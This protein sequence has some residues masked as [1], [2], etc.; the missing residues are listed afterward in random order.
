[1]DDQ[2]LSLNFFS[3][4]SFF[5]P[6]MIFHTVRETHISGRLII[7]S[8]TKMGQS[9]QQCLIENITLLWTVNEVPGY[10]ETHVMDRT[11]ND[12][13]HLTLKRERQLAENFAFLSASTDNMLRVMALCVEEDLDKK[14]MT[15][16]LA[17]NTGELLSTKAGL[18]RITA[19]LETSANR[20]MPLL[21]NS[22]QTTYP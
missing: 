16:R 7:L 2:S 6:F 12:G 22:F 4:I 15:I 3:Y 5:R 13:R 14:G 1:M 11:N 9:T 8:W 19:V 21:S 17:S 18:Q 20:G 10:P